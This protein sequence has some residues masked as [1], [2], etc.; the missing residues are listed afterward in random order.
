MTQIDHSTPDSDA[1]C[2]AD[3]SRRRARALA[4]CAAVALSV[5]SSA[6]VAQQRFT[7]TGQRLLAL[8]HRVVDSEGDRHALRTRIPSAAIGRSAVR[9][10]AVS[11]GE[12]FGVPVPLSDG[13][14]VLAT[15]RPGGLAWFA[16]GQFVRH[17]ALPG[18]VQG[19]AVEGASGRVIVVDD[20]PAIRAF[21]PDGTLRT[22]LALP[23]HPQ[24]GA[25][26][27]V[28]GTLVVPIAGPGGTDLAV[29]APDLSTLSR[30]RVSGTLGS[31]GY[32]Y[33]GHNGA[34]WFSTNTGPYFLDGSRPYPEPL[35]WAR[36]ATAA[37]Q[38]DEDSL[39]VQFGTG[40][41][42][43]LRFTSTSGVTR[44]TA[45]LADQIFL[46]PRG[47]VALAQPF[48][49]DPSA[50]GTPSTGSNPQPTPTLLN[51][52]IRPLTRPADREITNTEVVT[53]DRRAR[54][55]TRALLPPLRPLAVL[56]DADD[57][58]LVVTTTGRLFAIDPGGTI[59]WQSDLGIVPTQDVIAL[60][61]GGFA[62]SIVRPRPGVCTVAT[63]S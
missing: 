22:T 6:A 19:T 13:S 48:Y 38:T 1:R 31:T 2:I 42:T 47:H 60:S 29:V 3:G 21:G 37:W 53:Y 36:S 61:E 40:T 8:T 52:R 10:A 41:P 57:G 35:A 50:S 58:L 20:T 15:Q 28:D 56:M 62:M 33:R 51:P 25:A 39:V 55:V 7:A 17:V 45:Q 54:R 32:F 4:L 34:L 12:P 9:C 46:L 11:R 43:E 18:T 27:L 5:A 16:D 24:Y 63:G 26:P 44:G 23:S 49:A 14:L 30:V 59:R